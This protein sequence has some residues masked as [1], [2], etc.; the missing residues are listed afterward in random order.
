MSE[1]YLFLNSKDSID[2]TRPYDARWTLN[3]RK[4]E[5]SFDVFVEQIMF[6]NA[7]YAVNSYYKTLQFESTADGTLTAILT[8][9]NYTA[10][11]LVTELA[12]KLN[13][14]STTGTYN[15]SYDNQ[16]FRLTI[17]CA[18]DTFYISGGTAASIL[19]FTTLPSGS[20]VASV[21][22]P[23]PLRLDGTM[24][25]DIVCSLG[26]S[27]FA[28]DNRTNIFYR[29]PSQTSIGKMTY[30]T[31]SIENPIQ[32]NDHSLST[33]EM[34]LQ[35]DQGNYYMLPPNCDVS[36]TLRLSSKGKK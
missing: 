19:G 33:F 2:P 31:P 24:Y 34:R 4:L 5:G 36:V 10:S 8:E 17:T 26:R 25:V 23:S 1:M 18:G 30:Y 11:Q 13:A 7:V 22:A 12:A 6:P 15:V 14:V 28:T 3:F 35:D 9:Q 20:A 32:I 21:V 29:I 16:T 27:S